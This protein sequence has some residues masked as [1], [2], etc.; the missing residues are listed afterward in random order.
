[1]IS[2]YVDRI[3]EDLAVILLGEEEFQIEIPC[4]L[5][6]DNINEGNY[7]KLDIKK[8]KESTQAALKEAME[9]MED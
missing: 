3:E 9:L 1:M 8:D 4:S 5:L 7:I 2:G 6:P